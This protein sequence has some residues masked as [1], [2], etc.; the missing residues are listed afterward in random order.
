VSQNI[1]AVQWQNH[2]NVVC[3]LIR[4]F[5][6][7]GVDP[8][9]KG[10]QITLPGALLGFIS[11]PGPFGYAHGS[12]PSVSCE[13]LL[14]PISGSSPSGLAVKS[15]DQ[16]AVTSGLSPAKSVEEAFIVFGIDM[17]N[18]PAVPQDFGLLRSTA[19]DENQKEAEQDSES[20]DLMNLTQSHET[21]PRR[22]E[23]EAH[24]RDTKTQKRES[25]SSS[26]TELSANT[27]IRRSAGGAS[28]TRRLLFP[29]REGR[30]K[31]F[32][33]LVFRA[34]LTRQH[35]LSNMLFCPWGISREVRSEL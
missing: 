9:G 20:H 11:I 23:E 29:A 28:E 5:P 31:R 17:G 12:H 18:S 15:Q 24:H 35:S 19:S 16:V 4:V 34:A 13:I 30:K 8:L 21:S 25:F 33:F 2:R 10:I 27:V 1:G 7:I 6:G 22:H 26:R 14:S 32:F 3:Y